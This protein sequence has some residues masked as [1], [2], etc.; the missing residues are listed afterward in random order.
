MK[1][2]IKNKEYEINLINNEASK[3]VINNLPIKGNL[4]RW[5]DEVYILV[6]FDIPIEKD[7]GKIFEVGD[8]I[9]WKSSKSG[10]KGIAVF[11]GNTQSSDKPKANDNCICKLIGKL[12]TKKYNIN[13]VEKGSFLEITK[14]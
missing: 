5:G 12:N 8:I 10:N 6:D 11:F 4:V 1:I 9:Y 13:D 14:E 7:D 3:Q 2:K